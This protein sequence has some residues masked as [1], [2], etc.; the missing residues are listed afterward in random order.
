MGLLEVLVTCL[1]RFATVMKLKMQ[2]ATAIGKFFIYLFIFSSSYFSAL[3]NSAHIPSKLS[4]NFSFTKLLIRIIDSFYQ[5]R[6]FIAP[7]HFE[8]IVLATNQL[9]QQIELFQIRILINH[10]K[11]RK[12]KNLTRFQ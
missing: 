3:K 5:S 6:L 4:E 11:K 7:A 1:H 10:K 2:E 9:S 8:M 12:K